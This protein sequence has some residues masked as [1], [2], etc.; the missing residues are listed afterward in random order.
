[1]KTHPEL[2]QEP[3]AE[4]IV[5]HTLSGALIVHFDRNTGLISMDFPSDSYTGAL[6]PTVSKAEVA[7]AIGVSEDAIVNV[8]GSEGLKYGVIEV[9]QE[10]DISNLDVDPDTLV[11]PP[12]FC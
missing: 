9:S 5:F 7:T 4:K 12:F 11:H 1:M 2:L 6:S 8:S 3:L 10:T